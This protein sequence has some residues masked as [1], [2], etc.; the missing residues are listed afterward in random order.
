MAL[1]GS[2]AVPTDG[3][4]LATLKDASRWA[5]DLLGRPVDVSNISYLVQYG[6]LRR[7]RGPTGVRIDLDELAAYY[8]SL[9]DDRRAS[10]GERLGGDLNWH[11]AFDHLREKDTTK[12]V[13]RLHPYKGKFIPQLVEYFLDDHVDDFKKE[14]YFRRGDVVLDPFCGSGT[15][16]VQAT[17][18]GLHSVGVD[19]SEFN[20]TITRVKLSDYDL[21]KLRAQLSEIHA[22]VAALEQ[23]RRVAAFERELAV[24]LRAFNETYF[25]NRE[26]SY[27]VNRGEVD[28]PSYGAAKSDEFLPTY[29]KLAKKHGIRLRTSRKAGFLDRWYIDSVREEIAFVRDVIDAVDEPTHRDLLR[30]VLSRAVRSS[31]ATS[32]LDLATLKQPQLRTYYCH[33]HYKICKPLFSL[34]PK[35]L[36][37]ARDTL[38]RLT[39]YAALKEDVR[40]VA[41]V[42]DSRMI[43]IARELGRHDH[44]LCDAYRDQKIAGIFSS[45]PYVGQIDY[46]EQHAYAYE[47]FGLERRDELEIGPLYQG[48]GAD[49]RRSYIDGIAAVLINCKRFL[50]PD[51]NVFLVAND[52]HDLYPAIAEQAGM[53]IVQ[54]FKRP[55]MNRTERDKAPYAEEI[56]H[57]KQL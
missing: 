18:L 19:V 53:C 27:R 6:K 45:P 54:R 16:L 43:D 46:H 38:G 23:D 36:R 17:E 57:L 1:A 7:H 24:E 3:P 30:I 5:S 13:H 39:E 2:E 9:A 21:V 15:T 20:T 4:R 55:V 51:Y 47:L 48:Q 35:F 11:L 34:R 26:F 44:R 28:E 25:P 49:A 37:Y 33:K 22:A 12:H 50:A 29:H 10:W 41:L 14:R 56:F 42:G 40:A 32:H 31:R 52:R 8:G